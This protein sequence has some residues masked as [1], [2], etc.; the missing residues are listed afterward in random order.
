MHIYIWWIKW[1]YKDI[2]NIQKR[3]KFSNTSIA[4][5]TKSYSWNQWLLKKY[6]E[7]LV[8]PSNTRSMIP[9]TNIKMINI[10]SHIPIKIEY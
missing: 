5:M 10:T 6:I 9:L 1:R 2:L 3:K 7:G 4:F 8:D